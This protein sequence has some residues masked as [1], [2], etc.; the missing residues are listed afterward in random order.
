MR[1]FRVAPPFHACHPARGAAGR[2]DPATA[3]VRPNGIESALFGPRA[4]TP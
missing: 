3:Q 1:C 2:V 4:V